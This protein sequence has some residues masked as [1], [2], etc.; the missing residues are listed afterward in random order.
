MAPKDRKLGV[1]FMT[2]FKVMVV[3][4][5]FIVAKFDYRRL[6]SAPVFHVVFSFAQLVLIN[7]FR[8]FDKLS[9]HSKRFN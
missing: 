9:L 6:I 7:A 3:K 8:K 1:K 2:A 5:K 4:T